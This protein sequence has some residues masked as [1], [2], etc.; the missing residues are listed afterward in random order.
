MTY[1]IQAKA[2]NKA[3]LLI[4]GDIGASWFDEESVEA[5]DVL[6]QLGG[7]KGAELLV[8]VNSKGGSLADAMAIYNAIKQHDGPTRTHVDGIA[9]SMGSLIAMASDTVEAAENSLLMVHAPWISASG[10]AP[11]LRELAGNLDKAAEA[12]RGCYQR[13]GVDAE[14][15]GAWLSDGKDHFFTAAEAQRVGLVDNVTTSIDIAAAWRDVRA[16]GHSFIESNNEGETVTK[17]TETAGQGETSFVADHKAAINK[18]EIRGAQGEHQRQQDIRALFAE[19]PDPDGTME[20][21]GDA[22][23]ADIKCSV[24]QAQRRIIEAIKGRTDV[25]L[26]GIAQDQG[27]AAPDYRPQRDRVAMGADQADKLIQGASR[28][29]EIHAGYLTDPAEIDKERNSEFLSMSLL[30]LGK[31]CMRIEG[32]ACHGSHEQAARMIVGAGGPGQGSDHFPAILENIANKAVMDGYMEAEETWSSWTVRGSLNDYRTASRVNK[33]LF[34]KLDK[35][36]ENVAFR[37]GKFGDVK[38]SITGFLHGKSFSLSLQAIVNDDLGLLDDARAWG[39]AANVTIGDAVWLVLT[40]AGTGGYGQTMDEDSQILFHAD[41]SNFVASGSGAAPSEATI[42][43]GRTA[44]MGQTDPNGRQVAQRPRY[45]LHG[46]GLTMDV[47]KL[48][49]SQTLITGAAA[50]MGDRNPVQSL[51]IQSV[52]EY[53]FDDWVSTA[54]IL[55]A[56]RR[57]VE[58][59]F[60]GGQSAPQVFRMA[61]GE[62]P[63][64][65]YQISIP[66]GVAGLDFRTFY[67]NYGA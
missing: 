55:A 24:D 50:T 49:N 29:L 10:N 22:C 37:H 14:L 6:R 21:L 58:V 33:S 52:E 18:G 46:T 38:Q 36:E 56:A 53:R 41:H 28:A 11:K 54:W 17:P 13:P 26:G 35:M 16:D 25:P 5:I 48:L 44:M 42:G 40:T 65:T 39:E 34:D 4:Y 60:V 30:E 32:K 31:Y 66:F 3:E 47:F 63:G 9:Y 59:A 61:P 23:L 67:L 20:A 51:G 64:I 1:Q 7:M 43:A 27:A 45:L 8:R 15:V 62:I 12:M 2:N 57:T 19:I